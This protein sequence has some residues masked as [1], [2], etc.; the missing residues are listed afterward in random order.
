MAAVTS[1]PLLALVA[2]ADEADG[3]RVSDW[4]EARGYDVSTCTSVADVRQCVDAM[5]RVD[6][7]VTDARLPDGDAHEVLVLAGMLMPFPYCVVVVSSATTS[8]DAFMLAQ[9]GTRALLERP[10]DSAMLEH[11]LPRESLVPPPLDRVVRAYIG[12]VD[13]AELQRR[14]CAAALRQALALGGTRS[15][16]ARLL[17][18]T[19]Q[20]VQQ[21]MR[22][23]ADGNAEG[24]AESSD[25]P[26][27]KPAGRRRRAVS[28]TPKA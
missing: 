10:L 3:V 13:L 8:E 28:R 9:A 11:A 23:E 25:G 1:P 19:R 6:L 2:L 26:P 27:A 15:G 4:L 7:V 12:Q 5:Q 20:A 18:V 16:A 14:V 24:S 21:M 22:A 17:K